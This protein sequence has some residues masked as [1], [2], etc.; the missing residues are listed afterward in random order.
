MQPAFLL[1]ED[2]SGALPPK[3]SAKGT[4]HK[5]IDY[6]ITHSLDGRVGEFAQFAHDTQCLAGGGCDFVSAAD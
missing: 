6:T 5:K 4:G 3:Q 2:I 1:P